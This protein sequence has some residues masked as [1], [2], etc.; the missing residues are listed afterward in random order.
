[1]L[2][3][4]RQ[5]LFKIMW[6]RPYH[7]TESVPFT[8]MYIFLLCD[9]GSDLIVS[10]EIFISIVYENLLSIWNKVQHSEKQWIQWNEKRGVRQQWKILSTVYIK[11]QWWLS[12]NTV[13]FNARID[14]FVYLANQ[15]HFWKGQF[16]GSYLLIF[17]DHRSPY[18]QF[19]VL[20]S[21][22]FHFRTSDEKNYTQY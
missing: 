21:S 2:I 13:F 18:F 8:I 4:F 3:R 22:Y 9:N 1:M 10:Y 16:G 6:V 7:G 5:N 12:L 11:I 15:T 19:I 14:N 17:Q 20:I